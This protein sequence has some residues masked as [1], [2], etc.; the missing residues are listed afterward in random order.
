MS[1]VNPSVQPQVSVTPEVSAQQ[2][3]ADRWLLGGCVITGS[4]IFGPLGTLPLLY[5]LW[6][7]WKLQKS[8]LAVRPWSV[9]I[10]GGFC[11][12]DCALNILPWSIALYAHDTTAAT[13]FMNGYGRLIDGGYFLAWNERPVLGGIEPTT[14]QMW[15]IVSVSVIFPM[16]IAAAWGFLHMRA[17]GLHFMKVTSWLYF[18]LWVGYTMMLMMD[19]EERIRPSDFGVIGWWIFNM[20]Y[21][22]PMLTLPYFYTVDKKRWN[23]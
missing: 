18:V 3:R 8:G 10:V 14:E 9:L 23:R 11:L 13:T 1:L 16:R 4:M 15:I 5:A 20:F 22:T 2:K 17:W 19:F 12:I 6:Q 7:Q 21:W